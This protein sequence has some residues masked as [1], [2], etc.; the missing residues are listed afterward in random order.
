MENN[1]KKPADAVL[2]FVTGH[3]K[4][5]VALALVLAMAMGLYAWLDRAP[6]VP[7]RPAPPSQQ[8]GPSTLPAD[9][10]P[11]PSIENPPAD[12]TPAEPQDPVDNQVRELTRK[13]DFYTF[14]VAGTNDGYNTDTILVGGIDVKSHKV[15]VM[16]VPRDSMVDRQVKY[17]KI[18]NAYGRAGVDEFR[19]ELEE[20]T[21]VY[22]DF[23]CILNLKAFTRIVDL[24]GGVEF[25]VP[26]D[27][28]HEDGVTVIDLKQGWQTLDGDQALGLVRFRG[29]SANDF[30]RTQ[31]QRDFIAAL[32]QQVSD[33]M[34]VSTVTGILEAVIK[35]LKTNMDVQEMI[36]FFTNVVVKMDFDTDLVMT[37][38]PI[39]GTGKYLGQD[40]VYL[41]PQGVADTVNGGI[42]PYTEPLIPE[43]LHIVN[44]KDEDY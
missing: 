44:L 12:S 22:P 25:Y 1:Q 24:V 23:Y 18:N 36:W 40:Y 39:Q 26:Y 43:D 3:K 6:E 29:T 11:D 27:M 21:G 41:D 19:D 14:V 34:S 15:T 28:Y 9:P 2:D 10:A 20:L 7:D 5:L 17:R 35:N 4:L 37:N 42:N 16:S 38:T 32:L 8:P 13:E 33:R 31:V 30:G